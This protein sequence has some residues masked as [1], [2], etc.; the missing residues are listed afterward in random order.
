M[1]RFFPGYDWSFICTD[2]DSATLTIL[3][4][5]A[6]SRRV[7]ARLGA[8]WDWQ[9]NVPSDSPE[10]NI[11]RSGSVFDPFV[12]EG[13]SLIYGFRDEEIISTINE[14]KVCRFGGILLDISDNAEGDQPESGLHAWDPW[15]Y[16][17]SRPVRD[18]DTGLIPGEAGLNYDNSPADQ[19]ALSLLDTTITY[20][21]EAFID[22]TSGIIDPCDDTDLVIQRGAS[23]GEALDQL[24][25]TNNCEI[26]FTPIYDPVL[27]PGYVAELNISPTIGQNQPDAIMA[28]DKPS[29]SLAGLNRHRDGIRRTNVIQF[30]AGQGGQPVDEFQ[31]ATSQARFGVYYEA[32]FFPGKE[33]LPDGVAS[34]AL[35]QL[36]LR[37]YGEVSY[38]V[39]PATARSPIPLLEYMPGD[40]VPVYASSNFR[41]ELAETLRVM[42]IPI[43]ISDDAEE[44]VTNM[45]LAP[46]PTTE[47]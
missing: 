10:V 35:R 25:A 47:S 16:L 41:E 1:P 45:L 26:M 34:D 6:S 40:S 20:D 19:I 8:A 17:Y 11:I 44:T 29:R 5:L 24:M 46:E 23:V 15:M 14:S 13:I 36:A 30:Y 28:W 18:P 12:Q 37:S 32:M 38:Q 3:D 43:E 31:D 2:L 21:G 27:R 33:A 42:E 4:R 7:T 39:S 9:A 22:I